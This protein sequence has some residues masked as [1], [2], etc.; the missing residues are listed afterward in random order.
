MVMGFVLLSW[1]VA[2]D[3]RI[4]LPRVAMKN[5]TSAATDQERATNPKTINN[6][7]LLVALHQRGRGWGEEF[8]LTWPT[9]LH[10]RLLI[11]HRCNLPLSASVHYFHC[12]LRLQTPPGSLFTMGFL[13][14]SNRVACAPVVDFFLTPSRSCRLASFLPLMPSKLSTFSIPGRAGGSTSTHSPA[15]EISHP[16]GLGGIRLSAPGRARPLQPY[17]A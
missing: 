2:V 17:L 15:L 14:F 10:L 12:N 7:S 5:F 8:R 11:R 9:F 16:I 1:S 6:S 13:T 3:R 4:H